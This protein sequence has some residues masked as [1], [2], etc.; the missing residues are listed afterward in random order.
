LVYPKF[1]R[2]EGE[3]TYTVE[4]AWT[5]FTGEDKP[6]VSFVELVNYIRYKGIPIYGHVDWGYTHNF[7]IVVS[8]VI[9]NGEWWILHTVV[10]PGLELD[11]MVKIAL[12]LKQIYGIKR[13]HPDNAQ[14]SF[15]KTFNSKGLTCIPFKKDVDAGIEAVRTQV[16]DASGC[17]R[18]KIIKTPDNEFLMQAFEMHHFKLDAG[19]LPTKEPDDKEYAD[20]MDCTRY[21]AQNLFKPGNKIKFLPGQQNP[22]QN[23]PVKTGPYNDWMSQKISQL[24]GGLS[25]RSAD[26][27]V[28]FD[29]S[30]PDD[31]IIT[32]D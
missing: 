31:I 8:T 24:T 1:D 10:V 7:S 21:G 20:P 26:G 4:Q 23:T 25:G 30:N 11:E 22:Y 6:N 27:S 15:I 12:E 2:A 9:P 17:R 16:I 29:F 13:W 3:N 19:G 14:P 5:V 32:D 18:L 28:Y